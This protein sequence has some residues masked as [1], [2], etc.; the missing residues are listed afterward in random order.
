MG[1]NRR[2]AHSETKIARKMVTS[3]IREVPV[4]ELAGG[5]DHDSL[6]PSKGADVPEVP[7]HEHLR[8]CFHRTFEDTV[9]IGVGFYHVQ[10]V[11]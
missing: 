9:V 2:I 1:M 11:R 7:G 5:E 10:S 3:Q 8:A 6:E 4:E